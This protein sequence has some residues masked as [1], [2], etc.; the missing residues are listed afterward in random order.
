MGSFLDR[1]FRGYYNYTPPEYTTKGVYNY[2][3]EGDSLYVGQLPHH[4]QEPRRGMFTNYYNSSY[5]PQINVMDADSVYTRPSRFYQ[6]SPS[7]L[8]M[9][10]NNIKN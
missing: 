10:Y 2:D 1:L 5:A 7:L 4:T 3:I 6:E 8:E 9:L